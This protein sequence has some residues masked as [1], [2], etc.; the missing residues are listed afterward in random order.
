MGTRSSA[1][2]YLIVSNELDSL[3][4]LMVLFRDVVF[5]LHVWTSWTG[6]I[7]GNYGTIAWELGSLCRLIQYC[8]MGCLCV[9]MN[10]KFNEVHSYIIMEMTDGIENYRLQRCADGC[11]GSLVQCLVGRIPFRV[12]ARFGCGRVSVGR[13]DWLHEC[14]VLFISVGGVRIGYIR[15][16]INVK[17]STDAAPVTG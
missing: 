13:S 7:P 15:S 16:A 6:T 14:A 8:D 11:R 5:L 17:Y 9:I 12:I 1:V 2:K 10:Q 4:F 3:L